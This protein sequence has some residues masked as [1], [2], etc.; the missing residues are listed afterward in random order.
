VASE[1]VL[2][3]GAA[4]SLTFS[5]GAPVGSPVEV[6]TLSVEVSGLRAAEEVWLAEWEGG[7]ASLVGYF[8]D[9]ADAWRGW[10][11]TKEW[12]GGSGEVR[13]SATHD[14]IGHVELLVELG[15][16]WHHSPPIVGAWTASARL[17]LEPGSLEESARQLADLLRVHGG[18]SSG[19]VDAR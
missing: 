2:I 15:V 8:V 1:E 6:V 14:G 17:E 12:S 5:I 3:G 11:G 9:L 4:G 19:V 7:P 13:L 18:S 10:A 16:H